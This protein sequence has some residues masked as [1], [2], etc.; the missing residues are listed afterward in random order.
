M[1]SL[2]GLSS[3]TLCGSTTAGHRHGHGHGHG[4]LWKN[5]HTQTHNV[6]AHTHTPGVSMAC[7]KLRSFTAN[8]A[9]WNNLHVVHVCGAIKGLNLRVNRPRLTC[10][11]VCVLST[12]SPPSLPLFLCVV[13]IATRDWAASPSSLSETMNFDLAPSRK[14]AQKTLLVAQQKKGTMRA[15]TTI[16]TA[17]TTRWQTAHNPLLP[18]PV[19]CCHS[20][21][22]RVPSDPLPQLKSSGDG[23]R[24][25]WRVCPRLSA[26]TLLLSPPF[27]CPFS[28]LRCCA[29][30]VRNSI[31]Y[32]SNSCCGALLR[33]S[34]Y[35]KPLLEMQV[36]CCLNGAESWQGVD[37]SAL[38]KTQLFI[39][40][41]II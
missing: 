20:C 4:Q 38:V 17:K 34:H 14:V 13:L 25:L 40:L 36:N 2:R 41:L 15:I 1:G 5:T 18:P 35:S 23:K 16:A 9:N 37:E 8:A 6:K 26:L 12:C 27:L 21:P 10:V 7:W 33:A 3:S 29:S 31:K 11:S 19:P 28:A 22:A 24:G 30:F 39:I 32:G